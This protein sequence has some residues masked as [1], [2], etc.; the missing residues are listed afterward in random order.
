MTEGSEAP[1]V[2]FVCL[3]QHQINRNISLTATY[4][5]IIYGQSTTAYTY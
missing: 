5:T 2:K 1:E 4:Y 3:L